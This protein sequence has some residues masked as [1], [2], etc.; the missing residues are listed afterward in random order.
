M[1]SRIS[2]KDSFDKGVLS[3]CREEV[4]L[5]VFTVLGLVGGNVGKDIKTDNWGRG[6]GGT[7]DNIRWTV[8]DIEEGVI[9]WVVKDW[10]G[11]LGGWGTW[12]RSNR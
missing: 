5:L 1:A 4:L 9:F 3:G 11:E 10:P 2:S 7:G 12:D 6:D 8:G